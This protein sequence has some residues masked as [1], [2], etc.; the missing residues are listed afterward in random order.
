MRSRGVHAP[1][2]P[3]A[4][5]SALTKLSRAYRP[6]ECQGS[7]GGSDAVHGDVVGDRIRREERRRADAASLKF[8]SKRRR[9]SW[10]SD[11]APMAPS[12]TRCD[13]LGHFKKASKLSCVIR[14]IMVVT[15][16]TPS[17]RLMIAS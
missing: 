2:L 4:G 17:A 6:Y 12:E 7:G 10:R 1:L 11:S 16:L 5:T 14:A 13:F 15:A 8:S 9:Q 3:F